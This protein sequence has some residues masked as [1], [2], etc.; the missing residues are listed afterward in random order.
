MLNGDMLRLVADDD[1]TAIYSI[2][3]YKTMTSWDNQWESLQE[4][5]SAYK[6]RSKR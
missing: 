1:M 4:L 5:T 2:I 6:R 3:V